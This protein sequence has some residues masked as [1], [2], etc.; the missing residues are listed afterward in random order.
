MLFKVIKSGIGSAYVCLCIDVSRLCF[1]SSVFTK[2]YNSRIA[3]QN[4]DSLMARAMRVPEINIHG[5]V[6][7]FGESNNWEDLQL[8]EILTTKRKEQIEK[9]N[10]VKKALSEQYFEKYNN[11][12]CDPILTTVGRSTTN[13][14]A[15]NY[16][17]GSASTGMTGMYTVSATTPAMNQTVVADMRQYTSWG[18]S[19]RRGRY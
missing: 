2:L 19:P 15:T 10:L 3:K 7:A 9:E 6:I 14:T 5:K 17:T 8:E 11:S 16:Y 4:Q 1:T 18:I 13:Y 12:Y